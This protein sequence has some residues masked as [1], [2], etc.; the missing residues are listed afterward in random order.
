MQ[1][2]A[3]FPGQRGADESST[4]RLEFWIARMLLQTLRDTLTTEHSHD[5]ECE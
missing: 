4:S 3:K 1:M 2:A 5:K